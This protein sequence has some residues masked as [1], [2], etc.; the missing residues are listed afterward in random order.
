MSLFTLD[1]L[2]IKTAIENIAVV[3]THS[4]EWLSKKVQLYDA[5]KVI[6]PGHTMHWLSK[7]QWSMHEM[8]E[9][10]LLATGPAKLFMSTWTITEEPVRKLFLL[11]QQGYIQELQCLLDYRI[12]QRK[13][14]P[15]QLMNNVC[16]R[17]GL[18]Q[19]HAKV[20]VAINEHKAVACVGSANFSRNPR[21]EAGILTAEREVAHF[22]ASWISKE[23]ADAER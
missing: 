16:D 6:G 22:H 9:A 23:I 8:V 12:K 5:V 21:I 7:G 13:A 19:C 11:K 18:A 1:A 17:L 15:F 20:A 3:G 14:A 2:S 10:M 4:C